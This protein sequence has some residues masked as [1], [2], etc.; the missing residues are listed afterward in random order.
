MNF[1]LKRN[2]AWAAAEVVIS[3]V[4]LF[5]IYKFVILHLGVDA[6]G[7]WALVLAT[8]SFLRIGD[9]GSAAGLSRFVALALVR[10][11]ERRAEEFIGTAFLASIAIFTL[12]GLVFYVPLVW[13]L[14]TFVP[15]EGVNEAV[16]LAPFSIMSFVLLNLNTVTLSAL[17]G[18]QRAD[19]K[20][21]V[22]IFSLVVQLVLAFVLVPTYGLTGLAWAQIGQFLAAIVSA[23]IVYQYTA[24]GSFTTI[25][26]TRCSVAAFRELFGF[27]VKVQLANLLAFPF[28]PATK[29][30]IS[31]AFGLEI[32]G[33]YE[34][35]SRIVMQARLVIVA[36]VQTLVPA[37]AHL[38]E[39]DLA[40][41]AALY[42]RA[43]ANSAVYG[44]LLMAGVSLS[45]PIVS[46]LWMGS[47][48]PLFIGF[49]LICSFGW[50]LNILTGPAYQL[51]VSG[52]VFRWNITGHALISFAAPAAG[53]LGG[54]VGGPVT[55][56]SATM[57]VLG[58]S[59]A[60]SLMN[61]RYFNVPALPSGGNFAEA[62]VG[63][64]RDAVTM[65]GRL[66]AIR[67]A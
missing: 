25:V 67:R 31:S 16:R 54:I 13:A 36:P 42:H 5:L 39:T 34:L 58:T 32:L 66:M 23:R 56:V 15:S 30:V 38:G 20:S 50:T 47:M 21:L 59:S 37:L 7:I 28:E 41:R 65:G 46:W 60:I 1:N 40:G 17:V 11:D 19:L 64:W 62:A 45:S 26:P 4:A 43:V 9:F 35:A 6:V 2:S 55:I 48:N 53:W 49:V 33:I 61:C 44:G 3:G 63:V 12:L 14:R 57:A 22:V 27:G 24:S 51:G 52:D 29:F 10:K 8:T 18:R